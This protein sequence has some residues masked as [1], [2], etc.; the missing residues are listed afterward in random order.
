MG[1]RA[2]K[3]IGPQGTTAFFSENILHKANIPEEGYRD[4]VVLMLRPAHQKF[5]PLLSREYVG[6]FYHEDLIMNPYNVV[7]NKKAKMASE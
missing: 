4:A 5:D 7:P 3:L 2:E 6:S 1:Y